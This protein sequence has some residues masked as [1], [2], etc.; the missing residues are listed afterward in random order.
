MFLLFYLKKREKNS[1]LIEQNCFNF[2][3]ES[4]AKNYILMPPINGIP[5]VP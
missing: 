3:I 4:N 2:H 5:I 1:S